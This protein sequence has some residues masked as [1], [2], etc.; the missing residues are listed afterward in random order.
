[1]EAFDKNTGSNREVSSMIQCGEKINWESAKNKKIVGID[2]D[3]VLAQYPEGWI[4]FVNMVEKSNYQDLNEVKE[5]L[6]YRRYKNLKHQYRTSGFKETLSPRENASAF[7]N[8]LKKSGYHIF[9]LTSRPFETYEGLFKLTTNWLSRND[10]CYDGIIFGNDKHIKI[11]SN[12]PTLNFMVED[13]SGF[14]NLVAKWGYQVYLINTQYNE[15]SS[16]LPRVKRIDDLM[17]ILK[18]EGIVS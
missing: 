11:V 10:I 5:K 16:I 3:G 15:K 17:D 6:S 7:T 4:H 8:I 14:A 1:M 2:L 9:I 18:E 13:H 12:F